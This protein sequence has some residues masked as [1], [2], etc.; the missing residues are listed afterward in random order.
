VLQNIKDTTD[1][2]CHADNDSHDDKQS[3]IVKK[4]LES[5]Q[6]STLLHRNGKMRLV[7]GMG[8]IHDFFAFLGDGEARNGHICLALGDSLQHLIE[9][10]FFNTVLKAQFFSNIISEKNA[11]S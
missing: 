5:V 7:K 4:A 2:G 1:Q 9:V 3:L 6:K 8:K 10:V 11:Y